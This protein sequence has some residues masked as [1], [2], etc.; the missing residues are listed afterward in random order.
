V[1]DNQ[2]LEQG[3][4]QAVNQFVIGCKADGIWTAI[5]ASCILA[6][7]RTLAGALVPLVG[8]APTN[9]NFEAGDYNRKTGLAGNKSNKALDT[10]RLHS[11]DQQNNCHISV[12][13][14]TA[15]QSGS[16]EFPSHLGVG[17]DT[18]GTHSHFERA[19]NNGALTVR[20][21]NLGSSAFTTAGG[22]A[23]GLIGASRS[24][25]SQFTVRVTNTNSTASISSAA[26]I[27]QSYAVFARKNANG[28]LSSYSNARL[29]FYS[30]GESIDLAKLDTRVTD[31]I[32]AIGAAIP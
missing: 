32:T 25:S 12:F 3:V 7:A 14:H 15:P 6:G 28:V 23:T 29:A 27:G 1:A 26:P 13:V 17:S 30:I 2:A 5:K 18:T 9:N 11:A 22:G 24:N 10:N 19:Q 20:L 21:T 16:G 31:L 4:Q 8:T